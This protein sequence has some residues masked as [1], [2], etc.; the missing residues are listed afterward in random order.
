[1][2]FTA[3]SK[4]VV[5]SDECGL[6]SWAG[7]LTACAVLVLSSWHGEGAAD[8]KTVSRKKRK[9]L[10]ELWTT[11][12]RLEHVVVSVPAHEIDR[13]GMSAAL[14]YAHTQAIK[15][16]LL[17]VP[18]GD[19]VD[20]IVDG[21][22]HTHLDIPG[23]RGF[24]KADSLV[25]AVS[26]ASILGKVTHDLEM[27]RLA[28]LYPAYSFEQNMGYRSQA[29]ERALAKFGPCPEHRKSFSPIAKLLV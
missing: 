11:T 13:I 23:V 9:Q 22:L 28:K 16:L 17:K 20:V 24:P 5:G 6:G 14:I 10:Y 12:L 27:E 7:P 25:P 19:T 2:S 21:L 1:M 26:A 15:P 8:S 18:Q 4:W 29:H 3:S